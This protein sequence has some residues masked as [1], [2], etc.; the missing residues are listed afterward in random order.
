ML[1]SLQHQESCSAYAFPEGRF[2]SQA[3]LNPQDLTLN[4]KR[5][6]GG[7][8]NPSPHPISNNVSAWQCREKAGEM[9]PCEG[10]L[11]LGGCSGGSSLS[12]SSCIFAKMRFSASPPTSW[13]IL[14][15]FSVTY[16]RWIW[17]EGLKHL[18]KHC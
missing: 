17:C 8:L 12:S 4:D 1:T 13:C 3:G 14:A 18:F 10:S 6:L 16:E 2:T 11:P 9:C 7:R 15:E 5:Q